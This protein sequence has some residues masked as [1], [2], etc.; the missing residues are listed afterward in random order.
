MKVSV[1]VIVPIE[2]LVEVFKCIG[3]DSFLD[4]TEFLSEGLDLKLTVM[5]LALPLL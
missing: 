3:C 1:Q 4:L 2:E 5:N